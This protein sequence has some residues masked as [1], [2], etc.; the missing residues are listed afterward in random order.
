[1]RRVWSAVIVLVALAAATGL[2]WQWRARFFAAVPPTAP[3]AVS[4]PNR[5]G[6]I[7]SPGPLAVAHAPLSHD[8]QACHIPFR[9]VADAKCLGCHAKNLGLLIR[10][11]TAF[12]AEARRCRACHIEHQGRGGR[13]SRMEHDML[14]SQVACTG[15]HADRHQ[16]LFGDRCLDCH[17]VREWSVPGFRHPPAASRLC[18]ECHRAPPSH[19]MMHFEMVDRRVT[20]QRDAVVEQCWRCHTTDHW[21]NIVGVGLYQ[22]H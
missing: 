5:L 13:I 14:G 21:N 2:A 8:C 16:T 10:Q 6:W 17:G 9:P 11:D 1:M 15:C 3:A 7:A 4:W 12:H 18:V 22:H 20:G 19:F